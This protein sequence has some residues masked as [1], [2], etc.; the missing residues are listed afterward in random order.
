MTLTTAEIVRLYVDQRLS[1]NAISARD[2]RT[3]QAIRN[4]LKLAGVTLRDGALSR[5]MASPHFSAWTAERDDLLRKLWTAGK[6]CTAIAAELG[7][8]LT[9]SAVS[10]RAHRLGLVKRPHIIKS[11]VQ[12]AAML[13]QVATS[14]PF[15]H[16]SLIELPEPLMSRFR[17]CVEAARMERRWS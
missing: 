1:I 7:G 5:A 12:R 6:T 14:A 17:E 11:P 8:G 9:K 4:R 3:K 13:S 2:G 10:G 15:R 16:R